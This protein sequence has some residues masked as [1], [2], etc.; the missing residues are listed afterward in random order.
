MTFGSRR[1]ASPLRRTSLREELT[2][3]SPTRSTLPDGF[4]AKSTVYSYFTHWKKK[5]DDGGLSL[6]E[7]ALKKSGQPNT[8]QQWKERTDEFLN[9]RRTEREEH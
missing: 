1:T 4:P 2:N 3:Q 7:Q 6:L 5:P 8:Y 9:R